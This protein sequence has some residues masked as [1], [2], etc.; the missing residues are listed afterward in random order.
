[1]NQNIE[2]INN[3]LWA[4]K[5]SFIPFISEIEYKPDPEFPAY[6]EPARLLSDG[7]LILNKDDPNFEIWKHLFQRLMKKTDKQL[8]KEL[9]KSQLLGEK[10][11][12]QKIYA[13]GIQVE[14]ERRLKER[15]GHNGNHKNSYSII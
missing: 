15:G 11:I 3:H 8:K 13:D 6:K 4:V 7:L 5:F 10:T 12:W 9:K 14:V 2:V 1:M